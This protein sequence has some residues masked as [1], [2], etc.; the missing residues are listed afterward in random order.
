MLSRTFTKLSLCSA[1]VAGMLTFSTARVSAF[2]LLSPTLEPSFANSQ[3]EKTYYY[4]HPYYYHRYYYRPY[5]HSYYRPYYY[6]PYYYHRYY[7][8]Y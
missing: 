4:Y 6:H 2:T 3:I 8:Y 5:Y 7:H 1:A